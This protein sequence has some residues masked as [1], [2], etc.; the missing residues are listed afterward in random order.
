MKSKTELSQNVTD[1]KT[2]EKESKKLEQTI[3]LDKL[4][5]GYDA[6]QEYPNEIVDKGGAI[7]EELY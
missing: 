2:E 6:S 5:D 4:F 1:R 7:G 3:T